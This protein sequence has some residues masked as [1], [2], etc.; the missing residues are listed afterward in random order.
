MDDEKIDKLLEYIKPVNSFENTNHPL[1]PDYSNLENWAAYPGKEGQQF[2][3]PDSSLNLNK[4]D[5]DVDVFYIHPTGFFEKTW[6]SF[7]EKDRAS[8][9]RTEMM[10]GNQ[11]SA[12]NDSCN[13]YAPEYRQATYYSYFAKNSDGISAH[14]LAFEDV[15]NSFNYFIENFNNNKPFIILGHSQGALHAQRLISK[16]VQGTQLQDRMICAYVIGYIIPEILYDEL[17]PSIPMSSSALDT[18]CIISWSTVVKGYKRQRVRTIF[19]T[20]SGWTMQKMDQKIYS[21]NPFSWLNNNDWYDPPKCHSA[22]ITKS[23]NFDF[24]DRLSIKHSGA[25]KSLKYSSIQDFSVSV[26]GK[27]GLLEAK[28]PLVERMKKIRY[29]TGDLHSY[30]IMLFWGCLRQNIKDRIKAFD[31]N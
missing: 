14:D 29:F 16:F 26:N 10:L 13:I 1:P 7:M 11:V 2:Y 19:W 15:L 22:V 8:Y 20:P 9:E 24:A 30:D 4:N 3:L 27:N 28:G 31:A 23:P 21:T 18:N 17:F 25:K 5:N 12:F 6:N